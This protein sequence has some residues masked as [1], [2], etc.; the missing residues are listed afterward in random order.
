LTIRE[1]DK[2]ENNGRA[3]ALKKKR[4]ISSRY[5]KNVLAG[6]PPERKDYILGAG[7]KHKF[8]AQF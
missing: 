5:P 3:V 2:R 7:K 6:G 1:K 4:L 8:P